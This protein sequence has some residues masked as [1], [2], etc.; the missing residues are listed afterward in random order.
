MQESLFLIDHLLKE[1]PYDINEGG[2]VEIEYKS[3]SEENEIDSSYGF[4]G[5]V[6]RGE[7][8]KALGLN[9]LKPRDY[10]VIRLSDDEPWGGA[11]I[12]IAKKYMPQDFEFGDGVELLDDTEEYLNTR[13]FTIN[14]VFIHDGKIVASEQCVRDTLRNIVRVTEYEKNE[15]GEEGSIGPKMKAKALRLH[16]EQ[17]YLL[18][19]SFVSKDDISQ[20]DESYINPFWIAVQIDRA[21]ERSTLIAEKFT[22]TL[23]A[24]GIVPDTIQSANDLVEYLQEELYGDSF[25]FRNAP[26]AQYEYEDTALEMV[27]SKDVGGTEEYEKYFDALCYGAKF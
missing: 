14:E 26:I 16:T 19:K 13:D 8:R 1:I 24:H 25:Y 4:K 10:D 20:I 22:T 23:V 18:G 27:D 9:F 21:F 11:D 3:E 12:E 17:E 5:G 7:L 15:Y 2:Y 6:A